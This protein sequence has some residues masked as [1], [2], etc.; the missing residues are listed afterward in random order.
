MY[1]LIFKVIYKERFC[2]FFFRNLKSEC[3]EKDT[4][5]YKGNTF[6]W[7]PGRWITMHKNFEDCLEILWA[8]CIWQTMALLF[9]QLY[10]EWPSVKMHY[11][12]LWYRPVYASVIYFHKRKSKA[13]PIYNAL[14]SWPNKKAR[15]NNVN[16]SP[17]CLWE[18]CTSF[19]ALHCLPL[20]AEYVLS[21]K[22]TIH[23][24]QIYQFPLFP[25][26]LFFY[27]F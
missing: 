12:L 6:C 4:R 16:I 17:W 5:L 14:H 7:W 26:L 3:D 1:T 15:L 9:S 27:Q 19:T 8:A 21:N 2:S 22:F 25:L 23:T 13:E 18:K 11:L 20:N 10:M 24:I